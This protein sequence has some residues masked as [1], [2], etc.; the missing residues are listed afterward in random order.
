MLALFLAQT[1]LALP[2]LKN[3]NKKLPEIVFRKRDL[4]LTDRECDVLKLFVRGETYSGIADELGMTSETVGSYL[5]RV[6]EKARAKNHGT[7]S[8][9][10]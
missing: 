6:R 2:E 9:W 1:R 7:S 5:Q 8:H 4:S 3:G 10:R